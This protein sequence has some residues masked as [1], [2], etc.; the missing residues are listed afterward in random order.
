MESFRS[1]VSSGR[2]FAPTPDGYSS[3]QTSPSSNLASWPQCR[4]I[5]DWQRPDEARTCMQ[6]LLRVEL[7]D[8]GRG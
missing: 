3:R 6:E 1:P 7:L 5:K 8:E 2:Q 4:V